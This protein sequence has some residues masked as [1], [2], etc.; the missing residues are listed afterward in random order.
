MKTLKILGWVAA[1]SVVVV[2]IR[3]FG[4]VRRYIKIEMM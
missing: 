2:L 3:N 1:A 4:D